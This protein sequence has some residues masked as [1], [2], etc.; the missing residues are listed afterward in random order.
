MCV[1][2]FHYSARPWASPLRGRCKQ[3]CHPNHLLVVD[4]KV[5]RLLGTRS[6]AACWVYVV[7]NKFL[8]P[9]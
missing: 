1:G 2:C 6:I 5:S 4:L 8:G 7:I 3:I 9:I